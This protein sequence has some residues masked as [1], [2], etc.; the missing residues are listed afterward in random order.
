VGRIGTGSDIG[1]PVIP[2][3]QNVP[4]FGVAEFGDTPDRVVLIPELIG[5]GTDR[6]VVS[7]GTVIRGERGLQAVQVVERR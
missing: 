6:T 5:A 7:A 1:V 2:V 3:G 4:G